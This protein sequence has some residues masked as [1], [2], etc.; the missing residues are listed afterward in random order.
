MNSVFLS[1]I[2]LN[3][4]LII[5]A[6]LFSAASEKLL[7]GGAPALGGKEVL[8]LGGVLLVGALISDTYCPQDQKG[9]FLSRR[10]IVLILAVSLVL[11]SIS[12]VDGLMQ[13]RPS[14]VLAALALFV[15]FRRVSFILSGPGT[16]PKFLASKVMLLGNGQP[17]QK[18]R[19][20]IENSR[21]RYILRAAVPFDAVMAC[22]S[23]Q[24]KDHL[25]RMAAEVG[26]N[27][28]VVSFPE[29]RGVM[30]VQEILRCRLQGM[31][32][33]DAHSF[34]ERATRKL[35]IENM[36]PSCIIFSSGFCLSP[37]RLFVKRA[38][39]IIGSSLGILLLSPLFPLVALAVRLDSPGPVFFRQ[40]RTGLWGKSFRILKFRTMRQDAEKE[41]GAVWAT[42][43]DPRITKIG[44]FLRKTR[45]DEIPQLINV[46]IGDMSL[47]GP[48]PER[49]EFI[50]DLEKSIPFYSER[51]C[52]KP[53]VTGWAQV[54]YPYGASVD[55][56]LEKLRYDLYYIKNQSIRLELEIVIRT[57]LVIFTGSGAR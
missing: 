17:G 4:V 34:Y 43:K 6:L 1:R 26:A 11:F 2:V 12:Q 54:R 18:I 35:Y 7:F 13:P 31:T 45:L 36:T 19:E 10:S 8:I 57:I 52:V 14:R 16:Y 55:D 22:D 9:N 24:N 28:L 53:G 38:M 3:I 29:R 27:T 47:I 56:A 39:D 49:P 40:T 5:P 37:I 46:L 48:R 20:L 33:V 50:S 44:A 32:V 25:V 30:P 42:A 15:L 23:E 41:T 21:G 51:H